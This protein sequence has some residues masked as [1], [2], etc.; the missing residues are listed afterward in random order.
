MKMKRTRG[1]PGEEI[2]SMGSQPWMGKKRKSLRQIEVGKKIQK[3]TC[4]DG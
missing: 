2:E 3:N 1:L 4:V